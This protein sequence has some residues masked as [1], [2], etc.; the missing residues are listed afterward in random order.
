MKPQLLIYLL[1]GGVYWLLKSRIFW[2]LLAVALMIW[3]FRD[4]MVTREVD[5]LEAF[6]EKAVLENEIAPRIAENKAALESVRAS[7]GQAEVH[8]PDAEFFFTPMLCEAI[9]SKF[10]GEKNRMPTNWADIAASGAATNVPPARKGY[11]YVYD[12][13]FGSIEEVKDPEAKGK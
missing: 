6:E 9:A 5:R 2:A 4:T 13:R 11:K 7:G 1:L 12:A 10:H 8:G 3:F